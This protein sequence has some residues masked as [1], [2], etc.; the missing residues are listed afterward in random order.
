LL[1]V[2]YVNCCCWGSKYS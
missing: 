2:P 1:L